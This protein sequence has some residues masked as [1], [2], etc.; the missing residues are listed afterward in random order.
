LNEVNPAVAG[1]KVIE[2]WLSF[3]DYYTERQHKSALR[4]DLF[5]RDG[6]E[7]E[8]LKTLDLPIQSLLSF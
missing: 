7:K 1:A 4:S 8:N 3:K 5:V 6:Q 2:V